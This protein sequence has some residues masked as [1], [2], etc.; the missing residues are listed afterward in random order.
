MLRRDRDDPLP[1]H[2]DDGLARRVET[3]L[4]IARGFGAHLHLLHVTPIEAYTVTDAFATYVNANLVQ[5]LEDE[6]AKL[7]TRLEQQL[8]SEDVSWDYEE[9]T[10]V[11]LRTSSNVLLWRTS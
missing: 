11:S 8:T 6:A 7:K 1:V 3:A 10:S 5:T 2:D 9:V 4:S